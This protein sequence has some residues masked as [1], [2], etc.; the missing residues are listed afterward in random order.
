MT[1]T[2]FSRDELIA[3]A[4]G[5]LFPNNVGRL[6]L[7]N[8]LMFD[9]ITHIQSDGGDFKSGASDRRNGRPA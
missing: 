5:E 9:R 8:M 4:R 6:P 7:P 3:H 2:S 1:Q